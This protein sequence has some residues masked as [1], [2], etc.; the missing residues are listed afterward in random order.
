MTNTEI[1]EK[2]IQALYNRGEY[3]RQVDSVEYQTRCPFCG[4]TDKSQ[5][6]GH[7]YVRIGLEDN[8]P[9]VYNCFKC[10]A[11][12]I[13][14]QNFLTMME[15]DDVD[16][17]GNII[18]LNRTSDSIASHKFING[19]ENISFSYSLPEVV[20]DKKIKYIENRLGISLNEDDFT[21]LKIITSL[22]EFLIKNE[23]K[24]LTCSN[25][26]AYML[27][28][29]Y[30]GF[31]SYG[32]THILFRDITN[33][34]QFSWIKYPIT[35]KSKEARAI[36]C[37]ESEI[38]TFTKEP[39]TINLAEGVMDIISSYYN[40]NYNKPNSLHFGVLGKQYDAIIR[41]LITL[42]FVGDN[43][44][45]NVFSDNDESYNKKNKTPTDM[46]YFRKVF[47]KSKYLFK[48]VNVFYNILGKDIGVKK[49]KI[50]LIK[51]RI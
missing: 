46:E 26:I 48:E 13:V 50:S 25:E 2:M 1:K 12:G 31:L 5:R 23:V 20:K 15:I 29:Y 43:V 45:V 6:T 37:M 28:N 7:L 16:L 24:K 30:V 4:D 22:R 35:K 41:K 8:F 40:L 51:E 33:K 38:D 21:R 9:M 10:P 3:I 14:D 32:N 17:R 49:D 39:I 47:R 19:E 42:G 27:E 36:Y 11:S 44:T 18:S 34:C